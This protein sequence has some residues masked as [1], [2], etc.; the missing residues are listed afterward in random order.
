[1]DTTRFNYSTHIEIRFADIDA[2]GHVNNAV[3]LTY[4]E[5]ARS[6]YWHEVIQ[7][8][9]KALGVIIARAEVDFIRQLTLRDRIK[10]YVRT[11]RIGHTSFDLEYALVSVAKDGAETSVA[12]GMT[13]CVAFNYGSQLP[14][15]I[16]DTLRQ[17]MEKDIETRS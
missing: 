6:R 14:S 10:I 8:D 17:A 2:F 4:F 15:P 13:V 16:P 1:M 12:K 3:Y 7:W 9:W 5:V 11:S